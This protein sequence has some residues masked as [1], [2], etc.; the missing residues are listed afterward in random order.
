MGSGTERTDRLNENSVSACRLGTGP[1]GLSIKCQE[2]GINSLGTR[3]PR[4][5][6][7][8]RRKWVLAAVGV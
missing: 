7:E 8:E 4:K 2:F 1:G 6:L 5:A 3:E